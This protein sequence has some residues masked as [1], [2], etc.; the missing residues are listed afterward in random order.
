MEKDFRGPF[1]G[2]TYGG[3]HSS[4]FNIT[5]ISS[6]NRYSMELSPDFGDKTVSVPGADQTYYFNT[7]YSQRRFSI[8]FAFDKIDEVTLTQLKRWLNPKEPQRLIFDESPYKYYIAKAA[9]QISFQFLAFDET[10]NGGSERIYKGEG[11]IQFVCYYPFAKSLY[12]SLEEWCIAN[13]IEYS[14]DMPLPEWFDGLQLN[15]R[16]ST[17]KNLSINNRS[18]IPSDWKLFVESFSARTVACKDSFNNITQI[19]IEE[20]SKIEEGDD[21]LCFDSASCLLRGAKKH[22]D[23]EGNISWSYT[24]NVY[25]KYIKSGHFFKLPLGECIIS[26]IDI[27]AEPIEEYSFEYDY[28][29]Y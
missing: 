22:I 27:A 9:S 20:V 16:A 21:G 7:D 13:N 3:I 11:T 26:G 23:E 4:E 6:S 2:F 25:N 19:S 18:D 12:K 1:L 17:N 10:G 28:I 14:D 29:Y 5:R 24:D 15:M 8:P